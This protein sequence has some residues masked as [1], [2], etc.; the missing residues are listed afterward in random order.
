M[1]DKRMTRLMF[2]QED[3]A[4]LIQRCIDKS[5]ENSGFILSKMKTVNML[6]LA[7]LIS[8][9]IKEI[10]LRPEKNFMKI[11]FLKMKFHFSRW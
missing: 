4:N 1:T 3:A 5:S 8:K 9:N 7:T 10:G 6:K 11:L 2:S